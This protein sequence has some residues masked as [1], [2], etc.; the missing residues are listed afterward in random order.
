MARVVPPIEFDDF[1]KA[2]IR[3][4]VSDMTRNH[5]RRSFAVSAQI[6]L[7]DG[8]QRRPVEM[9][10]VGVSHQYEI[11]GG[12]ISHAQSRAAQPL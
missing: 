9:I 5:D 11:D 4:Q 7:H 6:I 2:Q 3:N 12:K 1:R 10:E 8:A